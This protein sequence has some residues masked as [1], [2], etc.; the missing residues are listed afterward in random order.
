MKH[1]GYENQ[2]QCGWWVREFDEFGDKSHCQAYY[3]KHPYAEMKYGKPIE[4][5]LGFKKVKE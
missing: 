4:C 1:C 5:V 2:N 3:L